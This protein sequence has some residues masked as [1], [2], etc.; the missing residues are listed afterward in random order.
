MLL[1]AAGVILALEWAFDQIPRQHNVPYVRRG[2]GG[3]GV[4]LVLTLVLTGAWATHPDGRYILEHGLS[5]GPD[6]VDELFGEKHETTQQMDWNFAAGSTLAINNPHGDVTIGTS[7]D[8]KLHMMVNKEVWSESDEAAAKH[9][10]ELNPRIMFVGSTLNV[11]VPWV[12]GA[13]TDFTISMPASG[14]V[15]VTAD[16]GSVNVSGIQAPVSVT[17]NHGDVELNSIGGAVEARVNHRSS[18][19]TAHAITGDVAVRGRAQDLDLTDVSG[20]VTLEGE[21]FGDTHLGRLQG[22]VSFRTSRTQLSLARLVGEVDISPGSELT[23][24][25]IVGPMVLHTSSRNISL[26]RIAG[27]IDISNSKGS[28]DLTNSAPLGNVTVENRDGAVNLILPE[29]AGLTVDAETRGGE[30]EN[31][32]NLSGA[33]QNDLASLRGNVGDGAARVTIRTNH[34]NIGIHSGTVLPPSA[35]MP[36]IVRH[37]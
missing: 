17:A 34:F 27:S 35:T 28:V 2:V 13:T 16:H 37:N 18:S 11:S 22:P 10:A 20:E 32:L 6:N 3:A 19:F 26:E 25:Q 1:V 14:A 23:G 33:T 29:H 36:L 5:I 24:N 8:G 21:F 31:D 4:V 9:A 7:A 30:I 15:R 12:R